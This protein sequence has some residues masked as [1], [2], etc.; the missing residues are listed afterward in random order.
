MGLELYR[1]EGTKK[2][3]CGYTTGTCAA[4]AAQAAAR[5]LL[6]HERPAKA[7]LLT[8][9]GVEVSAPVE[10]LEVGE[11]FARC[12]IRKDAGDDIDVTDGILIFA[13]VRP[14][15]QGI[16]VDGGRGV[17]RV[18]KPGL[19]QPVGQAAINQ[20]P[21]QMITQALSQ[22]LEEGDCRCG[23]EAII[24]IPQGEELAAKTFNPNLGIVGGLSVLG[25]SGIVEPQSLEALQRSIEVE[26]RMHRAQGENKLILTPGNYGEAFI[27]TYAPL[28]PWPQVKCA[29][30]IGASLDYCAQY[31]YEKVLLV[32][33]LGKFV[34]LAGG[35]MDTHSRLA[36]CRM[37]I[38]AAHA[39]LAG[40]EAS[41]IGQI[42]EAATTDGALEL[43]QKA[44]LWE[45]VRQTLL[46]KIQYHLER[47][48]A[49]NFSVGAI[50]YNNI[51][52]FLGETSQVK[53]LLGLM[54][55]KE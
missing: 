28:P 34:K 7:T 42:M 48:A 51:Q 27:R 6:L 26:I 31:G 25:T 4:L 14:I 32:G 17:G 12:A 41:L 45:K 35:V 39:A 50:I 11:G 22:V 13:Q 1:Q 2:L 52:G 46:Y 33:H 8:P 20:V 15:P 44:G 24:S 40:G 43:L 10:E 54:E 16:Q 47:R 18:T 38:L 53:G 55:E 9:K 19:N 29:N 36:D 37:E 30:F 21:R 49:G 23:L 3:R 5:A